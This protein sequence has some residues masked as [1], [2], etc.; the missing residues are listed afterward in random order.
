MAESFTHKSLVSQLSHYI[1][2]HYLR[3]QSSCILNDSSGYM[4]HDRCFEIN[5]FVPDIEAF[6]VNGRT[7]VIIGEAKSSD[8]IDRFHSKEQYVAFMRYCTE[9]D[10]AFFILAVPWQDARYSR[11]LLNLLSV[12]NSFRTDSYAVINNL[13]E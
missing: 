13:S 4:R 12:R 7:R 5:G 1:T 3:G 6:P 8:D 2:V 9:N 11:S 10:G